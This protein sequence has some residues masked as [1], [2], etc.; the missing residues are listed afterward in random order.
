MAKG[1]SDISS[2][3][4][5]TS[6]NFEN[7]NQF[8]DAFKETHEEVNRLVILNNRLKGMN[9][10]LENRVKTLEEE[11]NNLKNDFE[12]LEMIYKN[13]SCKCDSSSCENCESLQEKLH[14]LV[15]IV[16][17]LSKGKS[18]FETVFSSKKC[19]FG[20]VGLGF[21]PQS[22]K[23]GVLKPFLTFFEKQP[24]EKSNNQLFHASIVW[25]R[26]TLL[27]SAKLEKKLFP[28]V[29]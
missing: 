12:N 23:N 26:A 1:E 5:S 4:S 6:V 20:K 25:K 18:N 2:V 29:F 16:D 24:I 14:Y 15:K 21:N 17:K 11:L 19:V 7:Y 13:S 10:W 3:S 27:D 22:K 9:N 28:K 8:L